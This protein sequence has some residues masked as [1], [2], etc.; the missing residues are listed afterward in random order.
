MILNRRIFF[1][2][3]TYTNFESKLIEFYDHCTNRD[4]LNGMII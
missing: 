2:T 3:M 1:E 4:R